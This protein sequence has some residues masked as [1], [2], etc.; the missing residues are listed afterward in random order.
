MPQR[1]GKPYLPLYFKDWWDNPCVVALD[2]QG[3]SIWLDMYKMM[4]ESEEPGFLTAEGTV[5]SIRYLAEDL[6]VPIQTLQTYIKQ[7]LHLKLCMLR[8]HDG[9]LYCPLILHRLDILNKRRAAGAKG[10]NPGLVKQTESLVKKKAAKKK[11]RGKIEDI[12]N[13]SPEDVVNRMEGLDK[14]NGEKVEHEQLLLNLNNSPKVKLTEPEPEKTLDYSAT[15]V[16]IVDLWWKIHKEYRGVDP[17]YIKAGKGNYPNAFKKLH[18]YKRTYAEYEKAFRCGFEDTFHQNVMEPLYAAEKFN[19]LLT[20]EPRRNHA[21]WGR[22]RPTDQ[23]IRD[24]LN[25]DGKQ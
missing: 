20:T 16:E 2:R 10:G 19:L 18:S 25:F 14:Q 15:P 9:A 8:N 13:H 7:F 5:L 1:K 11:K 4:W 23:Q 12:L 22:Q 6:I 17:V 24:S 21:E 3:R